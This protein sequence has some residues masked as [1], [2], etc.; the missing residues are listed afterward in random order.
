[1]P[2]LLSFRLLV[3]E[4][5]DLVPDE[6]D[7]QDE[8]S[9]VLRGRNLQFARLSRSDLHRADLTKAD[10][11][12][13]EMFQTRL[14]K[15]KLEG[16]KLQGAYL[17]TAQLEGAD[18]NGAQ[19][20]GAILNTANLQG[21]DLRWAKL[22]GA[23]LIYANLQGADLGEAQLQGADLRG[24]KLQGA[25]F[26]LQGVDFGGAK[27][28][29]VNFG[30]AQLQGADFSGARLQGVSLMGAELQ[31]AHLVEAQLQG[32]DLTF[33]KLQGADLGR[34]Q[35][36]GADLGE[37]EIWLARFPDDLA[38]QAPVPLGVA[39]L[40]MSRPTADAKAELKKKLQANITDGELLQ[41]LLD[42]L[43]PILRDDPPKWDDENSWRLYVSQKKPSPPAEIV[44]FLADM[45][46]R[47]PTGPI[48]NAMS[49]RALSYG[50]RGQYDYAKPLAQALLQESCRGAKAL[51]DEMRGWL[52]NL[53]SAA[54]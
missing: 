54:E 24:A 26:Q 8:V 46:C 25:Y 41:R 1:M 20:Q 34:A 51:T 37:A 42:R 5:T 13:A 43:N 50:T 52:E 22:Q 30:V 9:R 23:H 45:A 53:V 3:V 44:Q 32:A 10:L 40:D 7:K 29:G 33:A 17:F 21:A 4:N 16:A 2:W 6:S 36:Q 19:L 11:R 48:A 31:G 12:G 15:A 18:L 47:D 28:K 39:D 49:F 35:L 27:L 38:D 14:E